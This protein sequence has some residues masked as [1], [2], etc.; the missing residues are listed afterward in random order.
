MKRGLISTK[1]P[2]NLCYS[3]LIIWHKLKHNESE[4]TNLKHVFQG[5]MSLFFL[6]KNWLGERKL[7]VRAN[8]QMKKLKRDCF[9]VQDVIPLLHV[10]S[11]LLTARYCVVIYS[12]I[13]S[14]VIA[15]IRGVFGINKPEF[16]F[17]SFQNS[18]NAVRA[19]WKL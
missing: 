14:I 1:Y 17:L 19:I 4:G 12:H 16:H 3:V 11:R 5:N 7:N 15:W 9:I 8:R 18:P 13:I 6:S 2:I 10:N